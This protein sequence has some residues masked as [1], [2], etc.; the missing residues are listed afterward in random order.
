[1]SDPNVITVGF[2]EVSDESPPEVDIS[3]K[4]M[5]VTVSE[6]LGYPITASTSTSFTS[7]FIQ[8][9]KGRITETTGC[10]PLCEGGW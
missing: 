6:I 8:S 4:P 10:T 7:A 5:K 1:M 3:R 2:D 9:D